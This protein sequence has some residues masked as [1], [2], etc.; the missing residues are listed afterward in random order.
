MKTTKIFRFAIGA[1]AIALF[2]APSP[3]S[4]SAQQKPAAV[5]IDA[6]DIGGVVAG[7]NG[8]EAGV[9]VVAV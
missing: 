2:F 1:M 3:I 5:Q 4:L 8:P 9:W 7:A 6:D